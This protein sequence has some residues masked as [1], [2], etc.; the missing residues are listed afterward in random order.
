MPAQII[1]ALLVEDAHTFQ[2]RIAAL[3]GAASVL[4]VDIMDGTFVKPKTFHDASVL[5]NIKDDI[6][7]ELD[8]MVNDPLPIVRAW[9]RDTR[10]VRAH[11][12][13]ELTTDVRTLLGGI[14]AL[15]L[16]AGL[17]VLP[18][19]TL[20]DI[21]HLLDAA[22]MV[23]I[24]GN[25]P[26]YSG[27]PL[28]PETVAKVAALRACDP[29]KNIAV[30]IGVN[31]QTIPDLVRAGATHLCVNSAIFAAKNPLNAFKKLQELAQ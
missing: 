25:E 9:A 16:E 23:L 2:A 30:D 15:G 24:R 22:D 5:S 18:Q 27:R 1:P 26:G 13:A 20:K 6:E 4:S 28:L 14:H 29:H 21:E 17:A 31:A 10:I 7:F 3:Q 19:T 8:L 11:V 12:H